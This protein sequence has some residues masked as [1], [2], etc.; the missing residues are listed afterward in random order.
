MKKIFIIALIFVLQVSIGFADSLADYYPP[1]TL[2]AF[3]FDSKWSSNFLGYTGKDNELSKA[4][5]E[6]VKC[7]KERFSIDIEND[8]KKMGVFLVPG[9]GNFTAVGI[10]SGNF[11][12]KNNISLIETA[13]SKAKTDAKLETITVNGKSVKSLNDGHQSIILYNDS[14]VL[15]TFNNALDDLINNRITLSKAPDDFSEILNKSDSFIYLSRTV[16]P[17]LGMLRVPPELIGGMTYLT[18][19]T[20]KSDNLR[21]E[22][23]FVDANS[24][25]QILSGLKNL[26]NAYNNHYSNEFQKNQKTLK[27]DSVSEFGNTI[28][29][30]YSSAKAKDLVDKLNFSTENNSLIISTKFDAFKI[31]TGIV[32]GVMN[33][34]LSSPQFAQA[35][36]VSREKACFA[37]I[38]VMQ[39]AT[40]MYNM[41]HSTMMHTLDIETL[42]KE[43]YLKTAPSGPDPDCNYITVGDLLEG[44]YVACEKHGTPFK[45]Q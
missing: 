35:R 24:A 30:M 18:G 37:N 12:T 43:K 22:I 21:I 28:L 32:G 23:G 34:V 1:Q 13:L 17:I 20:D 2:A 8:I 9:A 33:V 16:V 29:S 3:C 45:N 26:V 36:S 10:F 40:E 41:D 39:A 6:A 27:G 4:Y 38:R 31:I 14:V 44:G 11:N 15:F 5:Q 42:V 7:L 25:N 19:Y